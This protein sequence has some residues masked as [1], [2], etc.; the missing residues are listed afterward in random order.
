MCVF[1]CVCGLY[2]SAY[3]EVAQCALRSGQ[4]PPELKSFSS[5]AGFQAAPRDAGQCFRQEDTR[6][7]PTP[8]PLLLCPTSTTHPP[9]CPAM[10]KCSKSAMREGT[11]IFCSSSCYLYIYTQLCHFWHG[12]LLTLTPRSWSGLSQI[13]FA[14]N[15]EHWLLKVT[16]MLVLASTKILAS[17]TY[18]ILVHSSGTGVEWPRSVSAITTL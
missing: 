7:V 10:T 2:Y 12:R 11:D 18:L 4:T 9:L 5:L 16:Q 13:V 15:L 6:P 8:H 17:V 3:C 14:S 1:V